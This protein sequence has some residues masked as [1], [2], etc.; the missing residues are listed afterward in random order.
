[1]GV[2]LAGIPFGLGFA[3]KRSAISLS[4]SRFLG[5]VLIVWSPCPFVVTF[6]L[7]FVGMLEKKLSMV[8]IF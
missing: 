2:I 3:A 4:G 1:M 7:S 8:K 6:A 5:L